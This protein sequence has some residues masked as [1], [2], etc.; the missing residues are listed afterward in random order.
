MQIDIESIHKSFKNQVKTGR[1][2]EIPDFPM[3]LLILLPVFKGVCREK[4]MKNLII[5]LL[6]AFNAD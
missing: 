5:F 2:I 6:Q 3:V 4:W 1:D